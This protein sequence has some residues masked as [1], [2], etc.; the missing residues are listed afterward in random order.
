MEGFV[1]GA[2]VVIPFPFSDLSGSKRRPAFV[3]ADLPGDD[4]IVCQITSKHKSDPLALPL[5]N[6]DFI[7]GSL[8]LNSYIRPNKIFTADKNLVSYTAGRLSKTKTAELINS[9]ITLLQG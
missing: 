9:I 7:S 3:I 1:K 2:V 8:P 5:H 4:L 6:T